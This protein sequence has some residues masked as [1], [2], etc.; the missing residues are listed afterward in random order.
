MRLPLQLRPL[1]L[2]T[3]ALSVILGV[4]VSFS[5][6]H[7]DA[8]W[9]TV[10]IA[11]TATLVGAMIGTTFQRNPATLRFSMLGFPRSGKT[12][13]LT[14]LF[15]QLAQTV[16]AGISFRPYGSETIE[17]VN[18]N[19]MTLRRGKWIPATPINTVFFYRAN[20]LLGS[21]LLSR[22]YTL[23]IGDYA[24]EHIEEFNS[25][26][27]KW[28]HKTEYFKY[29]VDSDAVFMAVDIELVLSDDSERIRE[30]EAAL[31]AAMQVLL[32]R[33]GVV[34][35]NKLRTPV[36][37]VLLKCDLMPNLLDSPM[38]DEPPAAL[39]RLTTFCKTSCQN[40]KLFYV[41]SVGTVMPDGTPP[42]NLHPF[43]VTRPVIWTLRH[44]PRSLF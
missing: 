28:L 22:K 1:A 15:D 35:G 29:V 10:A 39:F 13:Y 43:G 8:R 2:A 14:V 25:G 6:I 11:I 38:D 36:A 33:K 17:A 32:D 3:A 42:R 18:S 7:G 5:A 44:L 23:E 9:F 20:V 4:A 19:L 34:P 37:L 21:G 12:V 24:G 40:F 27:E 30:V 41:S 31:I 26:N 16:D